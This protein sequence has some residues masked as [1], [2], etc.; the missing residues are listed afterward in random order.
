MKK[1]FKN[2]MNKYLAGH[3]VYN[4]ILASGLLILLSPIHWSLVHADAGAALINSA[5]VQR[6]GFT[7]VK[8][9][10]P[11]AAGHFNGPNLYFSVSDKVGA[12]SEAPNIVMVSN[13]SLA[14]NPPLG[15]LV[16]YGSDVHSF[17]IPGGV[18]QEATMTDGR[19]AINF[20]K[21]HNYVVIIG[22]NPQ[23]IENLAALV[24]GKIQ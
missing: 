11:T 13:Q 22:P 18:G 20:I 1:F 19:V 2:F 17:I 9:E 23:K 15:S 5:D 21:G 7:Q 24:A 14:Y 8:Q 12:D 3:P 6:S 4:L 10:M 16:V